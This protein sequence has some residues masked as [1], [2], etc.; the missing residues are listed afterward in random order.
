MYIVRRDEGI[1]CKRYVDRVLSNLNHVV[2]I[3]DPCVDI[4]KKGK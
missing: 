4:K 3:M 1:G 2:T